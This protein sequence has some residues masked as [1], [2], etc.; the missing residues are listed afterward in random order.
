MKID[1]TKRKILVTGGAGFLGSHI[2][3]KLL[4][5]GVNLNQI[6][7]PRKDQVDLRDLT[8]CL[9][10]VKDIDIIFH[11]AGNIGGIGYNQKYPGSILYDNLIMGIQLLEAARKSN[12]KK[13]LTI[14]TTCSYPNETFIPFKEENL[15]DGYPSDVTAPYGLAKKMLLV[16]SEAYHKQY[17]FNA[18]YLIPTNLYGPKDNYFQ[19]KSH[20]IPALIKKVV[21]AKI[22]NHPIIN[23]WGRGTATREFLYVKDAARAIVT[24]MEKY[25][26]P[27]PVN[28]GTGEEVSIKT[29]LSKIVN[30]IGFS[31]KIK[32]EKDKPEGQ[33]RRSLNINK[34][35]NEFGFKATTSLEVGLKK[36]IDWYLNK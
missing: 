8:N 14:G 2:I 20:V 32:W 17:N 6:V 27:E 7:I 23:V 31:G 15:W 24:A 16:Q 28:L 26:K 36:T 12:I 33:P 22:N 18:I 10:I 21:D 11:I 9:E 4:S 1:L 5:I 3:E 35:N 25:N 29:L 34:A 30:I 19:D 13:F